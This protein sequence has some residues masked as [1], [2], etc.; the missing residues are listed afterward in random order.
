MIEVGSTVRY[1]K[2]DTEDDKST[3]YY[4][5]IGTLG[6]VKI[7]DDGGCQVKWH[8]GTKNGA[9]WCDLDDVE[10]ASVNV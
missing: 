1:I 8:K 4:P 10:E 3:G 2:E 7:V 5:P 6:T 9:W